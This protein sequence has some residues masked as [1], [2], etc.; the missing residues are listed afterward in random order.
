MKKLV[1]IIVSGC[2]ALQ[3]V[4]LEGAFAAPAVTTANVNFRQGPGTGYGSFGTIPNGSPVE[5]GECNDTGSWCSVSFNGQNGFVSGNYLQLTEPEQTTGWP[6]SYET[7]AGATLIL[8]QPQFTEWENFKTVKA[9]IAAEYVVGDKDNPVFG[10][11]GISGDTQADTENGEVVVSDIQVTQLDFSALDRTALSDLSLEIGKIMPTGSITIKEDRITAGLA[12]YKR[13]EDVQGLDSTA[14]PIFVSMDPAILVQTD[15]EAITAPVKGDQGLSFIV[16]TNWDILK[17]GD[18]TFYLRDDKS[19]MSSKELA[20]GWQPA[21]TLPGTITNLPDDDNWKDAREAVPP[22]PFP[23]NQAPKV[24]YSDKPAEMIVFDGQP[25]LEPVKGTGLE[26]ASNTDSDVFFEKSTSTWY[27]L[28]SGRWFKSA[29]LE[30]PWTFTTPDLPGDFQNIPEDAPYYS[31]RSSVPNTSEAEQARLKASIPTTARVELGSVTPEVAYAGDPEFNPIDGTSMSYAVNTSEQVIEVAGK[32]YVL[33]NGVWFVGDTPQGPFEVATSV[34]EEIYTIP[35]ESP[36]YNVTYV[37]VYETEPDAVWYG[38]TMGYLTGFLAWGVLVYGTGYWYRP[39]YRPGYRPIYYPRPVTY[40]IG[41]FYNPVRGAYGRYGYAYGPMR[42]IAGGGIYNPRTGGYIRGAAISGPRGS[43]GFI[44]AYN[45][46]TGNR[47]VAG[48]ARGIYGSWGGGVVRG[49]EWARTRD[50]QRGAAQRWRQDGGRAV[51]LD[52]RGDVFAG[53]N[54]SVYRREG[55]N[56]QRF[57][58]GRWS[59][60]DRPSRDELRDRSGDLGGGNLGSGNLGAALGGAAAGA[61]VGAAIANRP[62]GDR[63]QNRPAGD[64]PNVNRPS[65][66]RPANQPAGNRPNVNRPAQQPN[67]TRPANRPAQQR[68]STRPAQR[69]QAPAHLNRD[70]KSRQAGN[71]QVQRQRNVKQSRPQSRP[72]NR[73]GGNRGGGRVQRRR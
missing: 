16:N 29:S 71:R 18:G 46:R 65:N 42:G 34:P 33:Q 54:G 24:I 63:I 43:A 62:A 70:R 3:T 5:L 60:V 32:Y 67:V 26:W 38:Y 28:V 35:P 1:A 37:R 21:E 11:V 4:L 73:G 13:M 47:V 58:G 59:D 66:N 72:Q 49:P 55:E 20:S 10:V 2:V 45:P 48:G 17:T 41:A 40:G 15:G 14:P 19:W 22:Q 36:V 9:L 64:R 25:K 7:P 51:S 23:D 69:H 6:R 12:E 68:P 27:I 52:R 53:R 44:T 30:G 57:E 56:W 39:W 31:V 61:G 50:I 8:Y